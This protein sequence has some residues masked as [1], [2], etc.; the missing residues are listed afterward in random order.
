MNIVLIF[1]IILTVNFNAYGYETKAKYAI[2]VDETTGSILY[3][4]DADIPMAPS[5]M[6]KLMTT[7]VVFDNLKRKKLSLADKFTV[8]EN[9]WRKQGSKMFVHVNDQV[10]VED[11]LLGVIVQSGNDACITLAEGIAGSEETFAEIMNKKA[12]ELGMNNSHFVNST[13][14]PESNHLMSSR[15]LAKLAKAIIEDFPEYYHYFSIDSF[16]YNKI[17]QENRNMLLKRG[18]GVDG[19]KTGHADDAGYGITASAKKGN[20]RLILVVNGLSGTIERANESEK[21][22]Q[23]G[24]LN[25]DNISIVKKDQILENARVWLGKDKFIPIRAKEDIIVTLPK[26]HIDKINV[27]IEYNHPIKAPIKEGDHITASKEIKKL[28]LLSR[29]F[30]NISHH[31]FGTNI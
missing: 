24:F 29:I 27:M 14:W 31:I 26:D 6:S 19:L 18:I 15:D 28:P 3:Q 2:L 5:S 23:Y 9:A 13:G 17:R 22:L 8:S 25:F 12:K 7:Y 11:L 30:T 10:S 20:R 21:L 4:K 16:V 1:L